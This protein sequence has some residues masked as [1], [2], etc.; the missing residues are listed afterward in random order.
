MVRKIEELRAATDAELIAEHDN[1]AGHTSVGTDYYT[2]EL[3][4][5]DTE[6]MLKAS[7]RL[8]V[9]GIVLTS[10]N[11]VVAVLAVVIALTG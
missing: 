9:V 10:V 6:R 7:H 11:A 1:L 5:R 8:A 3:R 4:H 2:E